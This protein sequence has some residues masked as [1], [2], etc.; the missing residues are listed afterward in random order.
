MSD[1]TVKVAWVLA[2]AGVAVLAVVMAFG[3]ERSAAQVEP[4]GA[5]RV[6]ASQDTFVLCES[7]T[8]KTWV[9]VAKGME[10]EPAW[11]PAKR[12]DTEAQVQA[13]KART[14]K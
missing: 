10:M 6:V 8:G 1:N 14:N 7:A 13:W 3:P 5:Y 12:L 4:A 2:A 9:L 11:L